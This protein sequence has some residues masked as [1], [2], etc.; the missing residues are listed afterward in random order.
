MDGTARPPTPS[1]CRSKKANGDCGEGGAFQG[2]CLQFTSRDSVS[3]ADERWR[4]GSE[5][6]STSQH[7]GSQTSGSLGLHGS[8][9]RG[10]V[11]QVPVC[12]AQ[13]QQAGTGPCAGPPGMGTGDG[14]VCRTPWS[15]YWGRSVHK[16]LPN[17]PPSQLMS[18]VGPTSRPLVHGQLWGPGLG[19]W[20]S[21]GEDR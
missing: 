6:R 16:T 15:G 4:D 5:Q 18:R 2:L 1:S 11:P 9:E 7:W 13:Q 17:Q 8:G 3:L 10:S 19:V 20:P 21:P 14:S 12:T